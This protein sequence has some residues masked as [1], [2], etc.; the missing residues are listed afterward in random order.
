MG[1]YIKGM[2]MPTSSRRCPFTEMDDWG[3]RCVVGGKY[4]WHKDRLCNECP[5]VPVP[6]HGRLIDVDALT[7]REGRDE[8]DNP[9]YL[10][11]KNCV[12]VLPTVIP[13]EEE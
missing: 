11:I 13:A 9:A 4:E 12:D 5:L 3:M 1:I 10:L 7:W 6:P 2:E 8:L